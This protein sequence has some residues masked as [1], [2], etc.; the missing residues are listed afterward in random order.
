MNMDLTAEDYSNILDSFDLSKTS[1]AT[2]NMEKKNSL[3]DFKGLS[4]TEKYEVPVPKFSTS[5]LA[6][7]AVQ[8]RTVAPVV[9][10]KRDARRK[11]RNSATSTLS[12]GKNDSRWKSWSREEEIFLVGVVM[13]RFF[14]RGSL[15]STRADGK[16]NDDCWSYIKAKYDEAWTSYQAISNKTIPQERSLNAL[17][18][19]YKV[20]KAR[21][22]QADMK[23]DNNIEDFGSYYEEFQ[24]SYNIDNCLI[25]NT[26]KRLPES[27]H[28]QRKVRLAYRAR[29][30]SA[31]SDCSSSSSGDFREEGGYAI[32]QE[33]TPF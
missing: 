7:N 18:R 11:R 30:E 10:P 32:R 15:S 17:S 4:G 19:H 21:I 33:A 22:S 3:Y 26:R 13:D 12:T 28:G 27:D 2:A 5:P 8:K 9:S 6:T 16:A 29:T 23:G 14:K 24:H 20:M 1:G 25:G 31:Q